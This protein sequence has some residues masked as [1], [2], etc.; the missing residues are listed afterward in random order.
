MTGKELFKMMADG[1]MPPRIPFV[2]TIY[3]H[4]AKVIG[5]PVSR[6]C[7]DADLLVA[8][9]LKCYEIYRHDLIVLG[10]DIYNVEYEAMG[11]R[12]EYFDD[13]RLPE[14]RDLL[15]TGTEDLEALKIP[16]PEKD[17]RMPVFLAAAERIKKEVGDEV[18]VSGTVI[19]PF[20][21]AAIARGYES[22]ILDMIEDPDF[23]HAQLKFALQ[24]GLTY[25]KAF[26]DR[27]LSVAINES[28]IAPPLL[29]PAFYKDFAAP[30]ERELISGLK[31]YGASSVNLISGG[32]TTPIVAE[33]A[34]TGTSLLMCDYKN[35]RR[36]FTQICREHDIFLRTSIQSRTVAAGTDDEIY[37][38]TQA[39]L[40]DCAGYYKF[41]M[42]CGVVGYDTE[43]AR[44]IKFRE[45]IK[46]LN[47][48][49]L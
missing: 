48:R 27:G 36:L 47:P 43:P 41:I 14:T 12:F 40:A 44:V 1:K 23:A 29:S 35:D 13:Q 18:G 49:K 26:V 8:A 34:K 33:M 37:E 24:V 10:V 31:A 2:P 38:E 28:W 9:Q 46:E 25:G 15:V 3:E 16:D 17:G 42:G 22:F 5:Q 20:T 19:G 32:D 39:V 30:Y 45:M 7:Q 11:A 6:L 4:A 21:L